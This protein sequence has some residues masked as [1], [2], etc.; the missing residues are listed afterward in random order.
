M[1]FALHVFPTSYP[2]LWFESFQGICGLS[3]SLRSPRS[4]IYPGALLQAASSPL[5]G[6]LQHHRFQPWVLSSCN[7]LYRRRHS[8]VHKFCIAH[9]GEF[10]CVVSGYWG[11]T[12]PLCP[13]SAAFLWGI[14][15]KALL[16]ARCPVWCPGWSKPLHLCLGNQGHLWLM[17]LWA[18]WLAGL[19]NSFLGVSL[20]KSNKMVLPSYSWHM[21]LKIWSFAF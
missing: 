17:V 11:E 10:A 14:G 13:P 15:Y 6:R 5:P 18:R 9:P 8:F 1:A 2:A 3:A 19:L 16:E 20:H 4:C 21:C 12:L 7:L